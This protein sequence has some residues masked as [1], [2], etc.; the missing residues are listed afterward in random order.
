MLGIDLMSNVQKRKLLNDKVFIFL[1]GSWSAPE[2]IKEDRSRESWIG[3][4]RADKKKKK[5]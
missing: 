1:V 2:I 4:V 3:I 5:K